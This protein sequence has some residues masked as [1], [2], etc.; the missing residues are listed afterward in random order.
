M[1]FD[2]DRCAFLR[3]PTALFGAVFHR[4]L[5]LRMHREF[6]TAGPRKSLQ[7][8]AVVVAAARHTHFVVAV[9]VESTAQGFDLD[10]GIISVTGS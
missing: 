4:I 5:E 6:L 1:R 10:H 8:D 3:P 9:W 7:A 2:V